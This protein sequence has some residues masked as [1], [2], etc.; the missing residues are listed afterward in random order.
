MKKMLLKVALLVILSYNLFSQNT[1]PTAFEFTYGNNQSPQV[2]D[3][4]DFPQSKILFGFQWGASY[5]MNDA[6]GNTCYA[7]GKYL[8]ELNKNSNPLD[9]IIQPLWKNHGYSPGFWY[10]P[11]MTYEPTL[12]LDASGSNF[13]EILRPDDES[14]PIFGFQNAVI[15]LSS[16]KQYPLSPS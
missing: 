3:P 7:G 13:G 4:S 1:E 14:N 9:M 11:Y 16:P 2:I 5:N 10:A 15:P 6:L 12:P 8:K